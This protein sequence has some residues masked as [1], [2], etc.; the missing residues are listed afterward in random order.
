M[1][2]NITNQLKEHISHARKIQKDGIF[3]LKGLIQDSNSTCYYLI[4]Q[5]HQ[6]IVGHVYKGRKGLKVE[7]IKPYRL[8]RIHKRWEETNLPKKLKIIEFY[9]KKYQELFK[10]FDGKNMSRATQYQLKMACEKYGLTLNKDLYKNPPDGVS[11]AVLNDFVGF[12]TSY[13]NYRKFIRKVSGQVSVAPK[14][15]DFE[16][17]NKR[18]FLRL[19]EY[20]SRLSVILN[21]TETKFNT[22]KNEKDSQNASTITGSFV[23]IAKGTFDVE[24]LYPDEFNGFKNDIAKI[25]AKI[26]LVDKLLKSRAHGVSHKSLKALSEGAAAFSDPEL[27]YIRDDYEIGYLPRIG[28]RLSLKCKVIAAYINKGDYL[29]A[30]RHYSEISKQLM[31]FSP[32]SSRGS[33]AESVL[34][35]HGRDTLSK[36]VCSLFS[37]HTGD[38]CGILT[39]SDLT[40]AVNGLEKY[41]KSHGLN[42]QGVIPE[43]VRL[44]SELNR[45]KSW[46]TSLPKK[47]RAQM[48]KLIALRE[49]ALKG[50]AKGSSAL[51]MLAGLGKGV[52]GELNNWQTYAM[53]LA[54]IVS[55]GA[56]PVLSKLEKVAKLTSKFSKVGH[57]AFGAAIRVP[58]FYLT[59]RAISSLVTAGQDKNIS[60]RGFSH[61]LIGDLLFMGSGKIS[62]RIAKLLDRSSKTFLKTIS[63]RTGAY[64][65]LAK[66]A[67]QGIVS[68]ASSVSALAGLNLLGTFEER[69]KISFED[70]VKAFAHGL[71]MHVA[72]KMAHGWAGSL[73]EKV[74]ERRYNELSK[75]VET[76]CAK[77]EGA[78]SPAKKKKILCDLID[79]QIVF[80]KV[81]L[82]S[83]KVDARRLGKLLHEGRISKDAYAKSMAQLQNAVAQDKVNIGKWRRIRAEFLGKRIGHVPMSRATAES[84]KRGVNKAREFFRNGPF[85]GPGRAVVTPEGIVLRSAQ[86]PETSTKQGSV[87]LPTRFHMEDVGTHSQSASNK[88]SVQEGSVI[89]S[90]ER[91]YKGKEIKLSTLFEQTL[92]ADADLTIKKQDGKYYIDLP[93]NG[94]IGVLS[95]GNV[96]LSGRVELKADV[97]IMVTD[98]PYEGKMKVINLS[99]QNVA[100]QPVE[101]MSRFAAARMR[102]FEG[103]ILNEAAG[104]NDFNSTTMWKNLLQNLLRDP[105]NSKITVAL[106]KLYEYVGKRH[107]DRIS[108]CKEEAYKVF[109]QLLTEKFPV[110]YDQQKLLAH[111]SQM[112]S[113]IPH[114][115]ITPRVTASVKFYGYDYIPGRGFVLNPISLLEVHLRSRMMN[116]LDGKSLM[117]NTP[118]YNKGVQ[119]IVQ[120]IRNLN[121]PKIFQEAV[122]LLEKN[123]YDARG[124][125][126]AASST[127][128]PQSHNAFPPQKQTPKPVKSA[129]LQVSVPAAKA[130]IPAI[131]FPGLTD[132]QQGKPRRSVEDIKTPN[133][134]VSVETHEGI[135]YKSV[136][137][138]GYLFLRDKNG[139]IRGAVVL[140]GM[141]GMGSGD[142]AS[143]IGGK[144]IAK[145]FSE[146]KTL[147]DSF[148]AGDTAIYN[149]F[150]GAGPGAVATGYEIIKKA[151]GTYAKFANSGDSGGMVIRKGVDGKWNVIY[152]TKEESL[153][154]LMMEVAGSPYNTLDIKLNPQ[155]HI[156][157]N[158]MG[159][160]KSTVTPGEVKLGKGD[161]VILYSDGFSENMRTEHIL[162]VI[163][164]CKTASEIR[165]KLMQL[166]MGRMRSFHNQMDNARYKIEADGTVID[167]Q[168]GKII[169]KFKKDNITLLVN[170]WN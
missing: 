97:A 92:P 66:G 52:L 159:Q 63:A 163:S 40:R 95:D 167:K 28:D 145:A 117:E 23:T 17:P 164:G 132:N 84:A 144:A 56:V 121:K 81:K 138:D 100:L 9:K 122:K 70:V 22:W 54:G 166:A 55:G 42:T 2:I 1:A 65:R 77:Y 124:V 16:D 50:V 114:I 90:G 125:K 110:D 8:S 18:I 10:N 112:N 4:D 162:N 170:K 160:N 150:N 73:G 67:V 153:G 154:A 35:S 24:K 20:K 161:I 43:R 130:N 46:E 108:E 59:D 99:V 68:N 58:T 86:M 113:M 133:G 26:A 47:M 72:L 135:G 78:S 152:K 169:D 11:F 107:P 143:K 64:V 34:K 29:N 98:F 3:E 15:A 102:F 48:A 165:T 5:N 101:K 36:G 83:W 158:C 31:E 44:Q 109:V 118:E 120:M 155:N 51:A 41:R 89:K 105:Q 37:N 13:S 168:T 141:G 94:R 147:E 116:A 140:D 32:K 126:K 148:K 25:R 38:I 7:W 151:D 85:N 82:E 75:K 137:E 45:L 134:D 27:K 69:S 30:L 87:K 129:T 71:Q 88:T 49:R 76:L 104:R 93:E 33:K 106:N 157:T 6:W 19:A 96:Q 79:A 156:V 60:F 127:N 103:T 139:K 146:G 123:G 62:G 80:A 91:E 119:Q 74:N 149:E 21:Q 12:T 14:K 39:P 115:D 111:Q 53:I 128:H 61:V 136:N 131:E 142:K 57:A